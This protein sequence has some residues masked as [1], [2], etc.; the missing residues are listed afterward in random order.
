MGSFVVFDM[1]FLLFILKK[2]HK[3]TKITELRQSSTGKGF[4]EHPDFLKKSNSSKLFNTREDSTFDGGLNP[5]FENQKGSG[6]EA[7][8][9]L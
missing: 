8:T 9:K 3:S 7:R 2:P 1:K 6:E 4:H 5:V